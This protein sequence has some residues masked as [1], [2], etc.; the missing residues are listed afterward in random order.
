LKPNNAV[1]WLTAEQ[2]LLFIKAG[3]LLSPAEIVGANI[4]SR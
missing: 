2:V 1:E 4:G 3:K